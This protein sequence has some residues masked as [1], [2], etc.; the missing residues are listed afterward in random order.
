MAAAGVFG[1]L[2]VD[3]LYAIP[4]LGWNPGPAVVISTLL[5]AAC[6]GTAAFADLEC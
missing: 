2:G 6:M 1:M 5:I 3:A 4:V